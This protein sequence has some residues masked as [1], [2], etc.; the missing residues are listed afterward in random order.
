MA[1]RANWSEMG[2]SRIA[3]NIVG[4]S[5]AWELNDL[6]ALTGL[7]LADEPHASLSEDG[8]NLGVHLVAER[9]VGT[10]KL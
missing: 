6:L 4:M 9:E 8:H 7:V 10:R 1:P 3:P 2:R 5:A